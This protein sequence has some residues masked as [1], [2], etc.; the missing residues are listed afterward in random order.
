MKIVICAI[1]LLG[2]AACNKPEANIPTG[3]VVLVT[4]AP[5][6]TKLWGV[7]TNNRVVYFASSGTNST[8]S[9]GKSC[10]R[11]VQ[12]PTATRPSD[13]APVAAPVVNSY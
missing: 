7:K 5:D 4:T 3:R 10:S 12:V 2:L 1:A 8:E 13:G 9:C 6:G 11:D